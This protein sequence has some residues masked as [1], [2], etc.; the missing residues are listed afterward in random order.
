MKEKQKQNERTQKE[1]RKYKAM[2]QKR[3]IKNK[4]LKNDYPEKTKEREKN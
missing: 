4:V 3:K 1:E 2:W